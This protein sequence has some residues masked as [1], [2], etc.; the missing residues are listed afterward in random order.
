MA[1]RKLQNWLS[2]YVGD[3]PANQSFE[4]TL[5]SDFGNNF[6]SPFARLD[7]DDFFYTLL[8]P[9]RGLAIIIHGILLALYFLLCAFLES[10]GHFYDAI[11][12]SGHRIYDLKQGFFYL[13]LTVFNPNHLYACS[14]VLY[15]VLMISFTVITFPFILVPRLLTTAFWPKNLA[16]KLADAM[17]VSRN[18]LCGNVKASQAA[19]SSIKELLNAETNKYNAAYAFKDALEIFNAWMNDEN[20]KHKDIDGT[21][22]LKIACELNDN[23]FIKMLIEKAGLKANTPVNLE[24]PTSKFKLPLIFYAY[25]TLDADLVTF[26]IGKG[27]NPI[28]ETAAQ[29]KVFCSGN[30][31]LEVL[32]SKYLLAKEQEKQSIRD[33]FNTVV[34]QVLDTNKLKKQ[35]DNLNQLLSCAV[36]INASQKIQGLLDAGADPNYQHT[37][38]HKNIFSYH[39]QELTMP[40]ITHLAV[41]HSRG[42]LDILLKS[43]KLDLSTTDSE[44]NTLLHKAW[45]KGDVALVTRLLDLDNDIK[46]IDSP[47]KHNI[48]LLHHV[49]M[50]YKSNPKLLN[51][52]IKLIDKVDADDL[53]FVPEGKVCLLTQAILDEQATVRDYL[54]AKGVAIQTQGES[55]SPLQAACEKWDAVVLHEW[56]DNN[57]NLEKHDLNYV[58]DLACHHQSKT[59]VEKLVDAGANIEAPN[60]QGFKA[61]HRAVLSAKST[62]EF[63]R[64]LIKEKNAWVNTLSNG[65]LK[66]GVFLN[67]EN[68]QINYKYPPHETALHLACY[69]NKFEIVKV[70]LECG[71]YATTKT[72]V[73]KKTPM[74]YLFKQRTLLD[75]NASKEVVINLLIG[76]DANLTGI[77]E[78]LDTAI[79]NAA[80]A[81]TEMAETSEMAETHET[82]SSYDYWS[83][84]SSGP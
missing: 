44:G 38:Y 52:I 66:S 84:I 79:D 41:D 9:L 59:L 14:L 62:P 39:Y 71:A 46:A 40:P 13:A 8:Q 67:K 28:P 6:S 55:T 17:W 18:V 82:T 5:A 63:I 47:N 10:I 57:T 33:V 60:N 69:K 12:N 27:T 83:S 15:G 4:E 23:N 32:V 56:L 20:P 74:H 19:I 68:K 37:F 77:K 54:L 21:R 73:T 81:T 24:L 70:L 30:T 3:S 58:L 31:A 34:E 51:I 80:Q 50:G 43:D 11:F 78:A 65:L 16:E 2:M 22:Y 76:G 1:G 7:L 72:T 25:N 36:R 64:Y 29:N 75:S 42:A 26:L 61:L 49:Y 35:T 45:A 48:S 53:N